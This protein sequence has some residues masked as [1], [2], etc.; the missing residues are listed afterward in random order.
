MGVK[1]LLQTPPGYTVRQYFLLSASLSSL[2][3]LVQPIIYPWCRL[4]GTTRQRRKRHQRVVV[5]FQT[6]EQA[7]CSGMH[8][9]AEEETGQPVGHPRET[10]VSK[11]R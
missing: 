7:K 4:R 2:T 9:V 10:P 6:S 5:V 8:M 3:K 1:H 11:V